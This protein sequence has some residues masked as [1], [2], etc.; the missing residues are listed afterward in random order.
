MTEILS[1]FI[2]LLAITSALIFAVSFFKLDLLVR[3]PASRIGLVSS[4]VILGI[5]LIYGTI[6]GIGMLPIGMS[7][8]IYRLYEIPFL[9]GGLWMATTVSS[10]TSLLC[11]AWTLHRGIRPP[12]PPQ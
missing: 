2:F 1:S 5:W 11:L 10:A 8:W 4:L 12:Q 7:D 6:W 9:W 3:T